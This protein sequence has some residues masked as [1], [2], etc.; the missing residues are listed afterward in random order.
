MLPRE[1]QHRGLGCRAC[2]YLPRNHRTNVDA[3]PWV[4]FRV[5]RVTASGRRPQSLWRASP[6]D[7]RTRRLGQGP[8]CAGSRS[9]GE[10]SLSPDGMPQDFD[11]TGEPA[12]PGRMAALMTSRANRGGGTSKRAG[13]SLGATGP[14]DGHI[15]SPS[16]AEED[17]PGAVHLARRMS[18]VISSCARRVRRSAKRRSLA[19]QLVC[20]GADRRDP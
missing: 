10:Q 18:G 9:R 3:N 16:S 14:V 1:L 7:R 2:C 13:H 11:L 12:V 5:P 4:G 8:R 20:S 15:R 6:R 19:V 17:A